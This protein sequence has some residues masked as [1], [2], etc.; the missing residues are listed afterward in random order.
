MTCKRS[1][2]ENEVPKAA[3]RQGD[4]FCSSICFRVA[5]GY[6]DAALADRMVTLSK[7]AGAMDTPWREGNEASYERSGRPRRV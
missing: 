1:G 3:L 4:P 2:C 7:R 6:L 5:N